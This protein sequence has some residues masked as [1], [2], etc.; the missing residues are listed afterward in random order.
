MAGDDT[1]DGGEGDDELTGGSGNNTLDGGDGDED[2]V[3]YLGAL[4]VK[5]DLNMDRAIGSACPRRKWKPA[6]IRR[7]RR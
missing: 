5:V 7:T 1:L 3:I 2:I 6:R 4:Q